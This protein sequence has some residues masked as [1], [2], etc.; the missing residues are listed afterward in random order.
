MAMTGT[1]LT[2]ASNAGGYE[3]IAIFDY[4]LALSRKED[5]AI[6]TMADQ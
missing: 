4:Y 6:L 3:K 1:P 2:G 5:R